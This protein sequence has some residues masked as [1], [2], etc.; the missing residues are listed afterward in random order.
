MLKPT[1]RN[2]LLL[3]FVVVVLDQI[4]KWLILQHIPY[5]ERVPVL[6]LLNLTHVYNPG[7]AFS[8]LADA[9]GWQKHFF[10][11]LA[12]A[13]SIFIIALLRKNPQDKRLSLALS[14][15]LGGAIGNLIDR[16]MFGHVI[17]F[18]DV[19]WGNAHFPAFNVADSAISIGA[20]LMIWDSFAGSRKPEA[21][22]TAQP[23]KNP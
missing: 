19:Y 23:E 2:W 8:F 17:D 4:S 3:A 21:N 14:L 7:A 6:P 15:I 12:V 20:A 10:S 1:L 5:L 11:V 9:G 18:V 16:L 22:E 13:A